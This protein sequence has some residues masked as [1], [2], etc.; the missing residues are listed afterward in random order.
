MFVGVKIKCLQTKRSYQSQFTS[1][2]FINYEPFFATKLLYWMAIKAIFFKNDDISFI[3]DM[4]FSYITVVPLA[5][6][7]WPYFLWIFNSVVIHGMS[8]LLIYFQFLLFTKSSSLT[9]LRIPFSNIFIY[10][11]RITSYYL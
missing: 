11:S 3:T 5:Y 9:K 8:Y 2:N 1:N 7:S 4:I 10:L 6:I